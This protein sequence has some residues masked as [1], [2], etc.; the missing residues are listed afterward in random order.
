MPRR[1]PLLPAAA[2][3]CLLAC[4]P[5]AAAAPLATVVIVP[6]AP[7][8]APITILAET[9]TTAAQR[10]RGLS[11]RRRLPAG[12]GMLFGFN[13][14]QTGVCMWMK[15][16]HIPLV[17]LFAAPSGAILTTA[18]MQP[19][20]VAPHCAPAGARIRHVLEIPPQSLPAALS[21]GGRL[22][23]IR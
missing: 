13:P 19:R 7:A 20:T 4:L 10:R 11:H 14:P 22:T 17:A 6:A 15:D 18:A 23:V 1:S 8:A 9:A 16:T 2:L 3:A 5:S 21:G 12:R